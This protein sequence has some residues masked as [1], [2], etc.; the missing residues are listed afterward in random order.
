[1]AQIRTLGIIPARGGSK[2]VNRKNV[3]LVA[4]EPLADDAR[5]YGRAVAQGRFLACRA[6]AYDPAVFAPGRQLTFTGTLA[7]VEVHKIG[8]GFRLPRVEADVVYLWP[9]PLGSARVNAPSPY[10]W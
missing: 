1:M 3:R 8:G 4:G 7:G 2:G 5:P 6:G 9:E 10:T